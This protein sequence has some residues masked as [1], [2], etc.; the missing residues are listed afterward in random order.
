M[1]NLAWSQRLYAHV[2]KSVCFHL[3]H[4][5]D[6]FEAMSPFT[7]TSVALRLPEA[8][9]GSEWH[10]RRNS[11]TWSRSDVLP[12]RCRCRWTSPLHQGRLVNLYRTLEHLCE[13][14]GWSGR[15]YIAICLTFL[16]KIIQIRSNKVSGMYMRC[17]L[18]SVAQHLS[19]LSPDKITKEMKLDS[20]ITWEMVRRSKGQCWLGT[21]QV[22]LFVR[23]PYLQ[24]VYHNRKTWLSWNLFIHCRQVW[25][26]VYSESFSHGLLAR[27]ER[28]PTNGQMWPLYNF[29][30]VFK[31]T[32]K[33]REA[34]DQES[35]P[36]VLL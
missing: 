24:F 7:A 25:R 16:S 36:F 10:F 20:A 21:R 22:Q 33:G 6:C 23:S 19:Y 5:V 9:N 14:R 28:L 12:A 31:K 26:G 13:D 4:I 15:I 3:L 35:L 1:Y 34:A 2:F 18:S 8:V 32:P 17:I 30:N 11:W 29:R 27:F